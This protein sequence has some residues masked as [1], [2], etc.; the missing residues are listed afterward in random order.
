MDTPHINTGGNKIA[1]SIL[2]PGDPLRCKFIAE[3]YL[4]DVVQF[5]SVR[6][7][8]GF[9]GKYKGKEVS[10]M[11]TGMGMP[12]IGIYSY[13][14]ITKFGVK[15]LIRIGSCGAIQEN[16]NL[17]DIVI[18]QGASTNSNF[19][20]QYGLPGTFA[21]IA[22]YD[23]LSKAVESANKLG[24]HVNVGNILSSDIFY[25]DNNDSYL[26]WKKM[27]ILAI[28]MEAAALYMNAARLGVK[29]LCILTVSD[30]IITREETTAEER[31]TAFNKMMELS[32]DV[33]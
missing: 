10:V 26:L 7:M 8:F 14:L 22:S 32:L 27:G 33:V 6:N 1:E 28:E 13:E 17:Y 20:S 5:N 24:I 9:T 16:L 12:S 29:A 11:G 15:N 23:L 25:D 18:G 19:A 30:N 3:N 2:L 31:Q 4:T 21:P